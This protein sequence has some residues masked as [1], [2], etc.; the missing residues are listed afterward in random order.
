VSPEIDSAAGGQPRAELLRRRALKEGWAS[1]VVGLIIPV[2]SLWAVRVGWHLRDSQRAQGT[3]LMAVGT[4]VFVA[5][6][7]LYLAW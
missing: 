6:L 3:A 5:R 4:T 1:I 2:V 7:A